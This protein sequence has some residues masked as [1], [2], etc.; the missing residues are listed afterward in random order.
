MRASA[1][2]SRDGEAKQTEST[3]QLRR[4]LRGL[5][6]L[7][8]VHRALAIGPLLAIAIRAVVLT[9]DRR[10]AVSIAA[11]ILVTLSYLALAFRLRMGQE[12]VRREL[13]AIELRD[14]LAEEAAELARRG[15]GCS[16]PYRA[17][18]VIGSRPRAM[19]P[20]KW[21]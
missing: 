17:A 7:E 1:V 15:Q 3:R 21:S 6:A 13:C 16:H 10:T 20:V 2:A 4:D 19:S 12:L 5:V 14:E 11:V 8:C 18:P 9:Q